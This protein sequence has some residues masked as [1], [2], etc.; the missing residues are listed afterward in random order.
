[1]EAAATVH[2][3]N[4]RR[5]GHG[6]ATAAV[7]MALFCVVTSARAAERDLATVLRALVASA[8]MEIPADEVR[9]DVGHAASAQAGGAG[10]LTIGD[11]L[12]AF[13]TSSLGERPRFS[14]LLECNGPSARRCTLR[15]GRAASADAPAY[16][17]NLRFELDA[18]GHV[19][20][21]SLACIGVP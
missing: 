10:A 16:D 2:G 12:A 17:T 7:M 21:G 4:A 6:A 3:V 5:I 11:F 15:Y 13:M 1:M 8:D 19:V 14:R 20:A 9:C 18:D